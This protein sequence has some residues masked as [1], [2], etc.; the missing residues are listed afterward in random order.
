VIG[1]TVV[2]HSAGLGAL[3]R[4]LDARALESE[5]S[6]HSLSTVMTVTVVAIA[7]LH[8]CEAAVWAVSATS[9]SNHP[10]AF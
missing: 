1:V 3:M 4:R 7:A 8:G 5:G 2:I 6:R 10:G 9:H